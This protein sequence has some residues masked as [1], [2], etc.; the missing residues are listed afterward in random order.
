MASLIEHGED[1][2]VPERM[3]VAPGVGIFRTV[4]VSENSKL[5]SGQ[6]VGMLAGPGTSVP[7]VSPFSGHL[8]SILVED[9]ERLR[10][11]QPVA[12][13]RVN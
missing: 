4:G 6:I 8:T 1:L 12:W 13:L 11:G 3:I 7:I 9:G 5:E 10:E 2:L